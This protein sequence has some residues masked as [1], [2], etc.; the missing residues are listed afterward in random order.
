MA[1]FQ[2]DDDK[3]VFPPVSMSEKNGLLAIGGDLSA[4]RL[5]LGYQSGIFPW[6]SDSEQILWWSPDPRNVLYPHEFKIHRSLKKAIKAEKFSLGI[7]QCFSEVIMRCAT[8]P[9]KD[10]DGTWILDSMIDAYIELHKLGIAHSFETYMDGVL[11]GGLYGVAIGK[12]FVGESMFSQ[13]SEA[14][15]FS[16]LCL[17]RFCLKS[18]IDLIDCQIENP[19][20]LSLGASNISRQKYLKKIKSNFTNGDSQP[21]DWSHKSLDLRTLIHPLKY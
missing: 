19:F 7:N 15:K 11:V 10:Q 17:A 20:L 21:I 5:I 2:L 1:I 14:S 18:N 4:K 16:M 13:V 8:V 12:V 6:F 3:L 9:R